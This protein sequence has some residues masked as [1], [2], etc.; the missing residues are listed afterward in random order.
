MAGEGQGDRQ[1][2]SHSNTHLRT[3]VCMSVCIGMKYHSAVSPTTITPCDT[4]SQVATYVHTYVRMGHK[5]LLD[6]V[7]ACDRHCSG[8]C[9][10]QTHLYHSF[11]PANFQHLSASF[12]AICQRER[13]NLCIPWK[14]RKEGIA[15]RTDAHKCSHTRTRAHRVY[16][17]HSL[18]LG[19]K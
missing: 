15:R 7:L 1:G 19:P 12:G 5:Q 8:A 11:T 13:H 9:V 2:P 18:S 14:L 10:G 16:A 6:F 4:L 3:N 17:E